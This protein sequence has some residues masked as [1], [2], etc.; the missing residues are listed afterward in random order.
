MYPSRIR[1]DTQSAAERELFEMMRTQLT[2]EWSV[3]HS[4]GLAFHA[5]KPWAE[6][7]FVL[8]GPLGLFCLEAKGGQVG[9]AGGVWYFGGHPKKEGPFDQV[10][11]ARAALYNHLLP[12][13]PWLRDV[14][15]G[16]GVVMP[17]IT[18]THTGPDIEPQV[19]YDA[20]DRVRSFSAYIRRL[21]D[22]WTTRLEEQMRRPVSMLSEAQCRELLDEIR[23]DFDVRPSLRMQVG[24]AVDD[25]LRLTKEQY[26]RLDELVDNERVIIR[27]GPGAGKTLLAV[28]EARRLA[29]VA[30]DT[31]RRSGTGPARILYCCYNRRLAQ[32]VRAALK[33]CPNVEVRTLH[34][35]MKDLVEQAHLQDRLPA[36][37]ETDLFEVFYPQISIEALFALG[38][39]QEYAALIVD[40][41]QD[42]LRPP[43]L[44]VFDALLQNGLAAGT[45]RF[46]LDP[47]Q[48]LF[49]GLAA[50]GLNRLQAAHPAQHRLSI[51]CRNTRPVAV[52]GELLS[53]VHPVETLKVTGPETAHYWYRDAVHA[54]QLVA[55]AVRTLVKEGVAP[56]DIV[57]LSQR[58]RESSSLRNGFPPGVPAVLGDYGDPT[59]SPPVNTVRFAT[60][61]AFKGLESD[62]VLLID[63]ENLED[64]ETQRALYVGAS[65]ATAYLAVFMAETARAAY[66]QRAVLYGRRLRDTRSTHET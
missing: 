10:G 48:N 1:E 12:T 29:A 6:I 22:F 35:L 51:N 63:I 5:K 43:Y 13:F 3:C 36:A 33:D 66:E 40:E 30:R 42:L 25:L 41:A 61:G 31:A 24:L 57:I 45:W 39:V 11:S 7:D 53:G 16:Y 4:L 58:R 20:R 46:F 9:R 18:F 50:E 14:V 17:D 62:A 54:R 64:P 34:A 38:R 15:S 2:D 55:E 59:L 21:S 65:R 44:E 52:A 49:G 60:V 56:K 19:L 27:G 23:G 8:I 37:E 47:Y 28:A 26:H 32:Y